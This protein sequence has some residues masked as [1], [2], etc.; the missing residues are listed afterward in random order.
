MKMGLIFS[1]HLWT[2]VVIVVKGVRNRVQ[3]HTASAG[4]TM[5]KTVDRVATAANSSRTVASLQ[6]LRECLCSDVRKKEKK[7]DRV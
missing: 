4:T 5:V 3:N 6:D 1:F 7:L 2:Q